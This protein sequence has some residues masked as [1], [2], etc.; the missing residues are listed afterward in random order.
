MKIQL[1][2]FSSVRE[3]VGVSTEDVQVPQTIQTIED[4]RQWLRDRG[5][6]WLSAFAPE[7]LLR[8]A[9]NHE[10]VPFETLIEEGAEVAFFPP[11]TGG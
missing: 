4:V 9:L 5:E 1:R 6:P 11:V 8:A 10:M 2:L 7:K 3:A